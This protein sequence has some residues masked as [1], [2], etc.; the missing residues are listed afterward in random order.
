MR[1]TPRIIRLALPAL[2][3]LAACGAR[4][5]SPGRDAAPVP[6]PSPGLYQGTFPCAD[7]PGIE[8]TLWLRPDGRF[9][10]R[11]H[12][13]AA[14][15]GEDERY[16]GLGRWRWDETGALLMLV[17]GG[18]GRVFD[19][20]EEGVLA[21]RVSSDLPHEL[22]RTGE[23]VPFTDTLTLEGEYAVRDGARVLVECRTGLVWPL[24]AGGDHRRLR[25]QY[26]KVPRGESAHVTVR[27]RLQPGTEGDTL[28]VEELLRLEPA[29]RCP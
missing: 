15:D 25:H 23:L 26:G 2:A 4:D 14:G 10:M 16:Y 24:A 5:E 1:R 22:A 7:C 21:M 19:A 8:V 20:R 13:L 28:V 18:P 9:F 6:A 11:Q 17:G 12:Y 27:G 3:L 29:R